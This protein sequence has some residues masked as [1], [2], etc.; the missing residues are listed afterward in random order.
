MK[1]YVRC[2][3]VKLIHSFCRFGLPVAVGMTKLFF[4]LF[5]LK[6][7]KSFKASPISFRGDKNFPKM[8][9]CFFLQNH[10]IWIIQKLRLGT[11]KVY[12]IILIK[13]FS[14]SFYLSFSLPFTI[15]IS[16]YFILPISLSLYFSI[17]VAHLFQNL[18]TFFNLK[19]IE[20]FFYL[21]APE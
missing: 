20:L 8:P 6:M 14:L 2:S 7:W 16:F 19:S 12:Q 11:M 9:F 17:L 5:C 18:S 10:D 21:G 4:F 13:L 3:L 1:Y 15:H